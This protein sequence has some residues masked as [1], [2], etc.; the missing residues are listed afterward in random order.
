MQSDSTDAVTSICLAPEKR[1]FCF[2]L[3]KSALMFRNKT[4]APRGCTLLSHPQVKNVVCPRICLTSKWAWHVFFFLLLFCFFK[5]LHVC[6]VYSE[7]WQSRKFGS[8]NRD[9]FDSVYTYD[10]LT[11]KN[12]P[13]LKQVSF[14][15]LKKRFV[16]I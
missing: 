2:V 12:A 4:F 11:R 13:R 15:P 7:P 5:L 9:W 8:R 6:R 3:G 1:D 16:V 14:S 10:F